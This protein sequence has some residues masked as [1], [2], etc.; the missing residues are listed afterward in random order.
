V[1][2]L[3]A[4]E[5]V[6]V[7]HLLVPPVDFDLS[8]FTDKS[9]IMKGFRLDL[10]DVIELYTKFRLPEVI[11]TEQGYRTT[12]L[13]AQDMLDCF[14]SRLKK[15]PAPV[16]FGRFVDVLKE[17]CSSNAALARV[18]YRVYFF[19]DEAQHRMQATVAEMV[20]GNRPSEI[21]TRMCECP[22]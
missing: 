5:P 21:M 3:E 20:T 14:R 12:G 1:F 8:T 10:A 22:R 7:E 2:L 19:V 18:D 16:A 9:A 11:I 4:V 6:V 15:C 17:Q 13:D